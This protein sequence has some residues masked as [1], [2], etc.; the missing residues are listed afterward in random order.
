MVKN[1]FLKKKNVGY[2]FNTYFNLKQEP[3]TNKGI[4]SLPQTKILSSL[5]LCIL[6][7]WTFDISKPILFDATEFIVWNIEGLS[8]YKDGYWKI[9]VCGKNSFPF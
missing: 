5:Y 7:V 9:R 4:V 6:T 1:T 3:R 2:F 8:G